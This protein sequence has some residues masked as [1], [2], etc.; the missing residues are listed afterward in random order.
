MHSRALKRLA[1]VPLALLSTPSSSPHCPHGPVHP[2]F[3]KHLAEDD[4]GVDKPFRWLPPL[5]PTGSCLHA[6][7]QAP[8]STPKVAALDLDGTLIKADLRHTTDWRSEEHKTTVT[9]L[10]SDVGKSLDAT[11]LEVDMR[12]LEEERK[13]VGGGKDLSRSSMRA[14]SRNLS[15]FGPV[16]P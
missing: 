8:A 16:S 1:K 11:I 13:K 5:G 7:N 3:Q 15:I 6:V 4:S 2:F 9:N 12:D 14:R 10:A